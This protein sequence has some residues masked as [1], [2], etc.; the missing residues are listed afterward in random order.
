MTNQMHGAMPG[1]VTPKQK[2]RAPR[3]A[4]Q[5]VHAALIADALLK[6]STVIELTGLSESS[7]RRKIAAGNFPEPV[8][9]GK[10]CTRWVAGLVTLWLRE[11]AMA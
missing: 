3:P 8:K 10:R 7:I 5:S 9:D 11:R 4:T 1:L 2:P 6:I